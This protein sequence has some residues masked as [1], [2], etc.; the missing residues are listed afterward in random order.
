ML[1]KRFSVLALLLVTLFAHL[2][3]GQDSNSSLLVICFGENGHVA[4][5]TVSTEASL[6]TPPYGDCEE[7]QDCHDIVLALEHGERMLLPQP[8][9]FDQALAWSTQVLNLYIEPYFSQESPSPTATRLPFSA[10]QEP[11]ALV[12]AKPTAQIETLSH[13]V[14]LI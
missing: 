10:F 8:V 12:A 1:F 2:L 3:F 11:D 5:E 14:L 6:D 7:A 4:L 9:A 13:T